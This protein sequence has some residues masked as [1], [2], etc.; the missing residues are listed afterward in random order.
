MSGF[1][2][3]VGLLLALCCAA[4][5]EQVVISKIMYHPPADRPEYFELYNNTATPFD[6][7]NWRVIKAVEYEFP[8][9]SSNQPQRTFL[10]PFE[11]IVLSEAPPSVVRN[12]YGIP[13]SIRIFGPWKGKLKNGEDRITVQ[14][15]N[16]VV[17]CS[18]K[19][20]D[21]GHWPR[22]ADGPGHALVLQNPN[23]TVDDWRNWA[24]SDLPGG[25]PGQNP[26]PHEE[27]PIADPHLGLNQGLA[28]IE[29]TNVW[30]YDETVLP[31]RAG[32]RAGGDARP[33]RVA[34]AGVKW[35]E[36]KF[37]DSQWLSGAGVLGFT[38]EKPLPP[39]GQKTSLKKERQLTYYFRKQ[40]VVERDLSEFRIALDQIIDDGA[41][42]Y[43]NGKEIARVRMPEGPITSKTPAAQNVRDPVEE[44]NAFEIDPKLLPVGTNLLAVEVHQDRTNSSDVA[45][46][47]RVRA[48]RGS[49]LPVVVNELALL[50]NNGG[51]IELFNPSTNSVNLKNCFVTD[52]TEDLRKTQIKSDLVIA[53]AGLVA[54]GFAQLGLSPTSPANVYLIDPDGSTLI[55]GVGATFVGDMRPIG[56]KPAGSKAWF[57]FPEPTRSAPNDVRESSPPLKLNEI[58]FTRGGVDWIE[59]YNPL[60]S[61]A[62]LAGLVLST[63]RDLRRQIPLSGKI[64][65][66]GFA[67]WTLS[68]PIG[69][70]EINI[71]LIDSEN[72]VVDCHTFGPPKIG[73][74]WQ[75]LPDGSN[76]WYSTPGATR[77]SPNQPER[78]RDVIINEIMYDAPK[79]AHTSEY[80]ELFNRGNNLVDLS[81]WELTDAVRFKFAPGTQIAPQAFLV[82]AA[83][84]AR[85]K[86]VYGSIPVIGNY[87]GKLHNRGD[88]VRL[89]DR[90]GNLVNQVDF[91]AEGD[92][93]RLAK[94]KG[95]SIE[96]INPAMDN[97]LSSAWR[98]SDESAKS[99]MR[100]YAVTGTYEELHIKGAP[101]D[102]KELHFHLV[103]DAHV[104]L[105]NIVLAEQENGTN[106]IVN[107]TRLSDDGLSAKGWLCQGTHWASF[108][109]NGQLHLVAD[110][111]GDNR[112]N[113]AEIDVTGM[114]KKDQCVL[115][116]NA[117]WIYGIPRL[118]AQTWDHSIAG[119]FPIDV[120]PNLGT[121]G[122]PNSCLLASPP[123][124][125][126]ALSH[127]PAVP[128]STNTVTFTASIHSA[129]PLRM[130]ELLYRIDNEKGDGLW[131]NL[132]M[133]P[134]STARAPD[135]SSPSAL[136]GARGARGETRLF[137]T[138]DTT[139]TTQLVGP[140]SQGQ[141]FQFYVR[142]TAANGTTCVL[143]RNGAEEP[144]MFVVDNRRVPRDLR[145]ARFIVSA[146][147]LNAIADGN[148]P[149]FQ[150]KYPRHSNRYFNATFISN[151]QEIFYN[152]KIR[153]SGSPWTRGGGLDRPKFKLPEDRPF[154][155]HHHFYFDNDAAGGNY[156]NRVTRYWLYLMGHA[157]AENEVIRVVVNNFGIDLRED[158]EPVHNDLLDRSF[159]LGSKGQLYRI[160]DEWWFIDNWDRDQRDAEWAYK[161][162]DNPGRYRTE[163]MKRTN[164]EEDDFS[165]LIKFFKVVS[166]NKYTQS[167]IE[168]YLDTDAILRYSVVRAYI[169]DW[170][171]FTM[172]RGKNAFFYQRPTDGRFQFLQWDSDLAFGDPNS[173]F[174]GGRISSWIDKPYNRRL[175]N[176][177]LAEFNQKYTK[178]SLRFRTW[179]EQE[180]N[181]S[182]VS[183]FNTN[184]YLSWCSNRE[185][186]VLRELGADYQR[187]LVITPPNQGRMV[188]NE[189]ITLTGAAPIT[190]RTIRLEQQPEA[191]PVWKDAAH[192]R[193]TN[194]HLNPGPNK[195]GVKGMDRGGKVLQETSV[196]VL[197]TNAPPVE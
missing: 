59:L 116:F 192:W 73:E 103:G 56:R 24:A 156:N 137:E 10:K 31:L 160:D 90:W 167:E 41:V 196:T 39:P 40:F 139:C 107:G 197:R 26:I 79:S 44:L 54:L 23:R 104:A 113:R 18:V 118:I 146:H 5:A 115:K 42:Y 122:K 134:A 165:D 17:V 60:P 138:R 71:Y 86:E 135:G 21:R 190:L 153:N 58:H 14:D 175:H 188:T 150:F 140:K 195:F 95:S 33:P 43:L 35:Y 159:H 36:P 76:E 93:P 141:I 171:T 164:E 173:G 66:R 57:R 78:N 85:M 174:T 145:T 80:I 48:Y 110:G 12:A 147:D 37:D 152:G 75:A 169:A 178:D 20:G 28:L 98:D 4:R 94:G 70:E 143:P 25:S 46:A 129:T 168:R 136:N 120:P 162:S 2:R 13:D 72:R 179:L 124:Q 91:K 68:L 180:H 8:D 47:L 166:E 63:H 119:S 101:A 67:S 11:R 99:T 108:I 194:V 170:D 132:L 89:I 185:P 128:H 81:D 96:L 154:R 3:L 64:G 100:E 191:L 88:L 84:A 182:T 149:R 130:V 34:A 148:T 176:Y 121:P 172:G 53:P 16:G 7:A 125:V 151:E 83:N 184:F 177:Y 9:F 61:E 49:K 126:D 97:S 15:K 65:G 112:P 45:F 187:P 133:T 30:K 27:I 102:Y 92:W 193:F 62:S 77:N 105:E 144:A 158:T 117:R 127:S 19:Y 22:S 142:A 52:T 111:R 181:A 82:V 74:S 1:A 157:S 123:P 87:S 29:Y 6:I 155:S 131:T 186:A 32:E 38:K 189:I 106:L 161:A 114:N 183:K 163:W 69:K 55:D 51:F 109:T 50:P